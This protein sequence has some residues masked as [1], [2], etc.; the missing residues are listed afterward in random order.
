MEVVTSACF[1]LL[2]TLFLAIFASDFG[3]PAWSPALAALLGCIASGVLISAALNDPDHVERVIRNFL[4]ESMKVDQLSAPEVKDMVLQLVHHRA[5]MERHR[6]G[7]AEKRAAVDRLLRSSDRWIESLRTLIGLVEPLQREWSRSTERRNRLETRIM[8]LET[9]ILQVTGIETDRQLRETM[10]S[11]RLELSALEGL[12]ALVD[13]A[14]LHLEHAAS[15]F[16]ALDAKIAMLD[17]QGEGQRDSGFLT[18]QIESEIADVDDV[19]RAMQRLEFDS[20]TA[21]RS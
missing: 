11:R 13:R 19:I 16:G 8:E 6:V 14:L 21:Y 5:R 4:E 15:T 1:F 10:A 12:E 20:F 3:L 9:R 17:L 7:R 18:Q 2:I